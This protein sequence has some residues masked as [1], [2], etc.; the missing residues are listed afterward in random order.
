MK[1]KV[2]HDDMVK[3]LGE[4][5]PCYSTVKKCA[6]EYKR[7]REGT[8]DDARTGWPQLATTDV[9]VEGIHLKVM[10]D[11]RVAVKHIA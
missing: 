5:S 6:D 2:S 4:D 10:N 9:I 7:D 8:D 1:T 3:T 11:R